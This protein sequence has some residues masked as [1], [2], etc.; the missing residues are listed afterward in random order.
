VAPSQC[1][2]ATSRILGE[3]F[4]GQVRSSWYPR[5][6]AA[7]FGKIPGV[8]EEKLYEYDGDDNSNVLAEW[9]PTRAAAQ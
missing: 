5:K 4:P 2:L 9:D 6:T 1:A 3:L 8:T 7:D